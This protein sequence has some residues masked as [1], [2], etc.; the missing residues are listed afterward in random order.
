[1]HLIEPENRRLTR[2]QY[3]RMAEL[4]LFQDH[5]VLLL[6][7]E[8]VE[9]APQLN[10]HSV[11]IG[12]AERCLRKIFNEES[13]WIRT[14]LPLDVSE[15]SEPEPDVAVVPGLPDDYVEHPS[16]ALLIIE[17]SDTTLRLDRRK[18]GVY[19]AV[20]VTDYWII[21][22]VECQIEVRRNPN[23]DSLEPFGYR[24]ADVTI[25]KP[26]D[27]IAPLAAPQAGVAAA[28]FFPTKR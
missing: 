26:G 17:V 22:L 21:N 12:L 14:Q 4:G 10:P 27:T 5:H 7:G 8:I 2:T 11:A 9:M 23:A 6:D 20:G 24:Y 18:A 3:Y 1:M 25:L 28:D 13:Y 15:R 19:A 16:T